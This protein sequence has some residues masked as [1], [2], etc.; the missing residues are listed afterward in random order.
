MSTTSV[1]KTQF[2][3]ICMLQPSLQGKYQSDRRSHNNRQAS[4][5]IPWS[6]S[7]SRSLPAMETEVILSGRRILPS[8]LMRYLHPNIALYN[9]LPNFDNNL[10]DNLS[11]LSITFQDFSLSRSVTSTILSFGPNRQPS[12][13]SSDYHC[14]ARQHFS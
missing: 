6:L 8:M 4:S 3:S 2:L 5:V 13:L 12:K 14:T 9:V 11:A 10:G 1:V 7:E